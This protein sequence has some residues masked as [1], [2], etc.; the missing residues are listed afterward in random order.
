VEVFLN[1]AWLAL[2]TSITVIWICGLRNAPAQSRQVDRKLQLL[3]LAMLIVI[4]FP[5]I[6]MTDDM[7][8]MSA[9]EIEHVTRRADLLPNSDHPA[10]LIVPPDLSSFSSRH[11]FNLQALARVELSIENVRPES[12]STRQLA[13]RPPPFAA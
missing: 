5:V 10:D 6:S 9:A 4:L 13:N 2:S 11:P 12:R 1:I 8:A 7:Q 3:A